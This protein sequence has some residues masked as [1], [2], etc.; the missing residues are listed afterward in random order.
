MRLK[1]LNFSF[2]TNLINFVNFN[3]LNILNKLNIFIYLLSLLVNTSNGRALT[4][5]M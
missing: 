4:K 5:S 1:Y 2:D 3:N